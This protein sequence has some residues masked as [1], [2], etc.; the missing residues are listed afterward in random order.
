MILIYDY[1][2]LTV[3]LFF[4]EQ[5]LSENLKRS[6][7]TLEDLKFVLGTISD[8]RGM[9]LM[10]EM[11]F[12]DIQERYR[13]LAMYK[14]EVVPYRLKYSLYHE[15]KLLS[16]IEVLVLHFLL[17]GCRGRAGT[18]GQYWPAVE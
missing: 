10:V 17:I 15:Q 8:I 2:T 16:L 11:R 14:V 9:S 13:T 6:P 1:S 7:S 3:C 18:G 4:Y 5:H 12:T